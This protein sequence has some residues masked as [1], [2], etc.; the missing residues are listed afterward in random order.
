VSEVKP[1]AWRLKREDG[2]WSCLDSYQLEKQPEWVQTRWLQ[3]GS[4]PLYDQSAL[5]AAVAAERE[6]CARLCD[7]LEERIWLEYR[8]SNFPSQHTE[9]ESDGAGR[10]AAL[11]RKS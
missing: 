4:E 6:R 10:C 11:I 1:V 9:G 3:Q 5:D 2:G 8:A 7:D